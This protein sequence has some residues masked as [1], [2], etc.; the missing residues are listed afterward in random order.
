MSRLIQSAGVVIRRMNF[1]ESSLIVDVLTE[2]HGLISCIVSGVRKSNPRMSPVLFTPGYII[3]LVYY[4]NDPQKLWRIKEAAIEHTYQKIPFDIV[5]GNTALCICELVKKVVHSHDPEPAFYRFVAEYLIWLDE[6]PA[7]GNVLIHFLINFSREIGFEP[8]EREGEQH[9]YF[10]LKTGWFE[11]RLPSHPLVID[12]RPSELLY[13]LMRMTREEAEKVGMS[14]GERQELTNRLIDY[15]RY[16][17]HAFERIK[18]YEIL[19]R[20]W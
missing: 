19:Q 1:R 11:S 18:S 12:K 20:L 9:Q 10:D 17:T 16:H 15:V 8:K 13:Q 2:T 6:V 3:Q 4:E 7:A 5:R 14:R